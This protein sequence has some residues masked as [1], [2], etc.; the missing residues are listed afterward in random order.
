M[1]NLLFSMN[2]SHSL[3]SLPSWEL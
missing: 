1:E 2:S 3:L